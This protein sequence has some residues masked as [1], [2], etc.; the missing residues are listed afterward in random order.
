MVKENFDKNVIAERIK[1]L[2]K[3]R[4][5]TQKDLSDKS[6][7][8]VESIKLY[9]TARRIPDKYNRNLLS[10]ALRVSSDYLLGLSDY[11]NKWHEYDS[12]N[13][14]KVE[15]IRYELKFIDY[16][17]YLACDIS[18]FSESESK[19]FISECNKSIKEIY[20]EIKE[21]A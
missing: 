4:K 10:T 7:V 1:E 8:S 17:N 6:G 19:E 2:R 11:K 5:W 3:E 14:N 13:S 16:C 12:S 15:S 21:R 9:E 18:D 20:K